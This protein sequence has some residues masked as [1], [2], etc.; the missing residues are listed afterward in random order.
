MIEGSV[1]NSGVYS[2]D[3]YL[4][5]SGLSGRRPDVREGLGSVKNRKNEGSVENFGV[6]NSCRYLQDSELSGRRPDV[7]GGSVEN[8]GNYCLNGCLQGPEI[9]GRLPVVHRKAYPAMK[10]DAWGK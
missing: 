4:Q 6:Y 8:S 9:T 3:R 1:E 5:D 7:R 10:V 2:S